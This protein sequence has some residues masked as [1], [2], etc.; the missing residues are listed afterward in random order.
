MSY[1]T[2]RIV[3]WC[4]YLCIVF[5]FEPREWETFGSAQWIDGGLQLVPARRKDNTGAAW[6]KEKTTSSTWS[7]EFEMNA[8][9]P[10]WEHRSREM[11][12]IAMW[13]TRDRGRGGVLFGSQDDFDGLGIFLSGNVLQAVVHDGGSFLA[14][15][16]PITERTFG[17]CPVP[18]QQDGLRLKMVHDNSFS[19][20]INGRLCFQTN[21]LAL[22]EGYYFGISGS[23]SGLDDPLIVSAAEV[24]Q[25]SL[26]YDESNAAERPHGST[27]ESTTQESSHLADAIIQMQ[28]DLSSMSAELQVMR[29][30]YANIPMD[31]AVD[32]TDRL[33]R[34]E[35]MLYDIDRK[36]EQPT[37]ILTTRLEALE[38]LLRD[39]SS[40]LGSI[41]DAISASLPA[42]PSI[43]LAATV[44][45][46]VQ[47]MLAGLYVFY[48]KRRANSPKKY[49]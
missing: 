10:H 7:I 13:Y 24:V 41:P 31:R 1:Y 42:A 9:N 8:K 32:Y 49:I 15:G 43:W 44:L 38:H 12:G 39:H 6:Q 45:V 36:L 34:L 28:S 2:R 37:K 26:D 4:L 19:V 17:S 3:V 25:G 16:S 48:K 27:E 33:K 14:E 40:H 5:G 47:L 22:P 11:L 29:K 30:E 46:S 20:F 35:T 18:E 23:F 21:Q